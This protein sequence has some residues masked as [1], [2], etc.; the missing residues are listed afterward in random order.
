MECSDA[1]Q[2]VERCVVTT[3]PGVAAKWLGRAIMIGSLFLLKS[4]ISKQRNAALSIF[5]ETG[6][7]TSR[8]RSEVRQQCK[9]QARYLK[10][11]RIP[12]RGDEERSGNRMRR[13]Q[14]R[15]G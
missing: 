1:G 2:R 3:H 4:G 6:A 11:S 8:I 5:R 14:G 13:E 12:R 15:E 10:K 7:D 9:G